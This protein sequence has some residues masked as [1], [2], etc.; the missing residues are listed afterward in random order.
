MTLVHFK[1][2]LAPWKGLSKSYYVWYDEQAGKGL[3]EAVGMS[4]TMQWLL[5]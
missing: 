1:G 2:A 4:L 3:E 5:G